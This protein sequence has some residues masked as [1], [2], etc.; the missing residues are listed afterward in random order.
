[1]IHISKR[2][3]GLTSLLT[4][5]LVAVASA[6]PS[7]NSAPTTSSSQPTPITLESDSNSVTPGVS[8]T[9]T[10]THSL[11]TSGDSLQVNVNGQNI[12]VPE[13]GSVSQT[14]TSPDG[15]AQTN[16][17]ID[18]SSTGTSSNSTTTTT[19]YNVYSS[20]QSST[21]GFQQEYHSP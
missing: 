10:V 9:T 8:S 18:H 19:N 11:D 15:N 7:D 2:T 17:T 4:F 5:S 13:N 6:L 12:A 20:V 1:M 21:T 14:V 3:A 16:V